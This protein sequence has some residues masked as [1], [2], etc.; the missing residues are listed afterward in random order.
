MFIENLFLLYFVV[1]YNKF[2]NS[3]CSKVFCRVIWYSLVKYVI[4]IVYYNVLFI[5]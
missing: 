2:I 5:N 4:I 1:I 3:N